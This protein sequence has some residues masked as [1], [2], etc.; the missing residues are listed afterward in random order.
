MLE[1][2]ATQCSP[3]EVTCSS[4]ILLSLSLALVVT[5]YRAIDRFVVTD[6]TT[7]Q[8]ERK[9]HSTTISFAII[10]IV[11]SLYPKNAFILK[12]KRRKQ[13]CAEQFTSWKR[14]WCHQTLFFFFR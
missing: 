11:S 1:Q 7:S 12:G 8:R 6:I 3:V 4:V 13:G 14:V 9:G 2:R 5:M 10:E